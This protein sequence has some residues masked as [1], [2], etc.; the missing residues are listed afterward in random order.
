LAT[1]PL[2]TINIIKLG[3]YPRSLI[4]IHA[5]SYQF[6]TCTRVGKRTAWILIRL[7][8]P[9]LLVLSW[10]GSF[11]VYLNIFQLLIECQSPVIYHYHHSSTTIH[12]KSL[13]INTGNTQYKAWPIVLQFTVQCKDYIHSKACPK[14]PKQFTFKAH[15]MHVLL[16]TRTVIRILSL[17]DSK[18][19]S[20]QCRMF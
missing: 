16:I 3:V 1:I 4:R 13:A 6:S 2:Y 9:I 20:G 7:H 14:R 10:C 12:M 15:Q 17:L 11:L 8:G 19:E 18:T 5:V